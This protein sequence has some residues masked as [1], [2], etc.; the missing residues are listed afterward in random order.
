M[1]IDELFADNRWIVARARELTS[2]NHQTQHR[3]NVTF[4]SQYQDSR[5]LSKDVLESYHAELLQRLFAAEQDIIEHLEERLW[6]DDDRL[7]CICAA[8]SLKLR[9]EAL[10]LEVD[11]TPKQ[12]QIANDGLQISADYTVPGIIHVNELACLLENQQLQMRRQYDHM[13]M[14]LQS[15]EENDEKVMAACNT[16]WQQEMTER[17][18]RGM[19][20]ARQ[21]NTSW[22]QFQ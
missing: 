4:W 15:Q 17:L 5:A 13:R 7:V 21:H 3:L 18:V 9:M 14:V 2:L 22:P 19:S 1:T 16:T 12:L 6:A 8:Q 20:Q 11:L 10:D